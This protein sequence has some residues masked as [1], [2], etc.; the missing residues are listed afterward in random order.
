MYKAAIFFDNELQNIYNVKTVCES[1]QS[2]SIAETPNIKEI[3][4]D[5]LSNF[6]RRIR[7][8]RYYDLMKYLYSG[9]SYDKYSGIDGNAVATYLEWERSTR[10][11]PRACIVDWDRTITK[12]EGFSAPVAIRDNQLIYVL[13]GRPQE[14]AVSMDDFLTYMCG[15]KDRYIMLKLL[16]RTCTQDGVDIVVLTNNGAAADPTLLPMFQTIV[17]S[18]TGT[19]TK[20]IASSVS[21]YNYDKGAA[22]Q[23]TTGFEELCLAKGIKAE[24]IK[25]RGI[26]AEGIKGGARGLPRT[27]TYSNRKAMRYTRRNARQHKRIQKKTR[28]QKKTRVQR[29]TRKTGGSRTRTVKSDFMNLIQTHPEYES[30]RRFVQTQIEMPVLGPS[31]PVELESHYVAILHGGEDDDTTTSP[32]LIVSVLKSEGNTDQVVFTATNESVRNYLAAHGN[33]ERMPLNKMHSAIEQGLTEL[34]L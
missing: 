26:R 21:P 15:T 1:I 17:D 8:N 23:G 30:A 18:F 11:I 33:P 16:F 6:T 32:K 2:V 5:K 22:L 10:G 3:P 12:V 7:P 24:G 4:W 29:K 31:F 14:Y 20:I 34:F 27:K 28:N 25:A 19:P 13:E 9:D